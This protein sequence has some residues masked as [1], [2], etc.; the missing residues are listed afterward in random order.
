MT[1]PIAAAMKPMIYSLEADQ[2]L[3]Q[4]EY[5]H[6]RDK[7]CQRSL[8]T[9][10]KKPVSPESSANKRSRCIRDYENG[11]S[12]NRNDFRKKQYGQKG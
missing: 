11:K 5:E 2:S 8:K 6:T 10:S 9:F 1:V 3:V 4:R 12:I 7:E